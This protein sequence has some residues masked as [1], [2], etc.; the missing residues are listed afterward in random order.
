[1]QQFIL[2]LQHPNPKMQFEA[3]WALTNIA[4]GTSQHTAAVVEAGA[5][6]IFVVLLDSPDVDVREQ[7]VWAIGNIAGDSPACRDAVLSTPAIGKMVAM[8]SPES[9]Q[10]FV[11]NV[12]WTISNCMRGKVR[13]A[14]AAASLAGREKPLPCCDCNP[15]SL[16]PSPP[17]APSP[18]PPLPPPQP[19]PAH[20]AIR[21]CLPTLAKLLYS[22]DPD[23]LVDALWALSYYTDG[24]EGEIALQLA[25][26]AGVC[27]RVAALLMHEKADVQTPALR[28]VGNIVTGDEVQTQV[29]INAGA[30]VGLQHILD[31]NRKALKKEACWAVSNVMA[32]NKE[33]IQAA[34][35][36]N[37]VQQLVKILETGT[38]ETKREACW[39]L[40]NTTSG[41]TAEQIVALVRA[42]VVPQLVIMAN[43]RGDN[44]IAVVALEG[45]ENILRAGP[46][47]DEARLL[48]LAELRETFEQAEVPEYL[49]E[50]R[51]E[52]EERGASRAGRRLRVWAAAAVWPSSLHLCPCCP[53]P[54][55]IP[56]PPPPRLPPRTLQTRKSRPRSCSRST[57]PTSTPSTTSTATTARR[58]TTAAKAKASATWCTSRPPWR[59]ASRRGAF[60]ARAPPPV[61]RR[62]AAWRTQ[63][64]ARGGSSASAP[65]QRRR[66]SP[67]RRRR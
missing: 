51:N 35:D 31:S 49:D 16:L 24:E 8:L 45:L 66:P 63:T 55:L 38:R 36:A 22:E 17:L 2:F 53:A 14:A 34:I 5:I 12:A 58:A 61:A 43:E 57:S 39:A 64:L 54:L 62:W 10:S 37:L 11:R 23:T 26:E 20:D 21:S 7:A 42:S 13:G 15:P 52:S 60:S 44:K 41:G 28:T 32:G 46:V 9:K 18:P 48:S 30:L 59:A 67:V 40:S 19:A 4:S 27:S 25:L 33:Q 47:M 29:M 65:T 50:I 6:P 56:P 1:M 3:A